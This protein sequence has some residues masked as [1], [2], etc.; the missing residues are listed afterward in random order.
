MLSQEVLFGAFQLIVWASI[1]FAVLLLAQVLA[2]IWR[3]R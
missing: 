2:H 3:R 1:W